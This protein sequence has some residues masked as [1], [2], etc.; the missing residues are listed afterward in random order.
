VFPHNPWS[1]PVFDVPAF[2]RLLL[3]STALVGAHSYLFPTTCLGFLPD[4]VPA[5]PFAILREKGTDAHSQERG[6]STRIACVCTGITEPVHRFMALLF[7]IECHDIMAGA[8]EHLWCGVPTSHSVHSGRDSLERVL[9][10]PA[11]DRNRSRSCDSALTG[12]GTLIEEMQED[13][14]RIAVPAS[15]HVSHGYRLSGS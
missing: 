11:W 8:S 9:G 14:R 6:F 2:S 3:C 4:L 1:S 12:R 5:T 15:S 7:R 10:C 13:S